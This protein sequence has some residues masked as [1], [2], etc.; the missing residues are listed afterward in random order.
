MISVLEYYGMRTKVSHDW[1][2][3]G[4]S[5]HLLLEYSST[6]S[7]G[8]DGGTE[9]RGFVLKSVITQ[10][11][12]S[13]QADGGVTMIW[14]PRPGGYCSIGYEYLCEKVK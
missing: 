11:G 5:S 1:T 8:F 10:G 6:A 2:L 9:W 3:K 13:L 4:I 12:W 7:S 14:H